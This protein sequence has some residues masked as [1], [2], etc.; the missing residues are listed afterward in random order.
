MI[1]SIRHDETNR[2]YH[3][4]SEFASCSGFKHFLECPAMYPAYLRK[5]AENEDTDFNLGTAAHMAWLERELF[6]KTY[7]RAPQLKDYPGALKTV[8]EIK[9]QLKG[10]GLPVSGKKEELQS[11]LKEVDPKAVFWDDIVAQAT[12]G[13]KL[14]TDTHWRN[15]EGMVE[16]L[17]RDPDASAL[18]KRGQQE[19]SVRW[20]DD[21]T[22]VPMKC[23]FDTIITDLGISGDLK[24]FNSVTERNV[25]KQIMRMQYHIQSAWYLRGASEVLGR[26]V[27]QF[28]HLFVMTEDPWLVV[29]YA[30]D[31]ASIERADLDVRDGLKRFAACLESKTWP[32][33][34]P[35]VRALSLPDYAFSYEEGTA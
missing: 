24:T 31:D 19:V 10:R 20:F 17:D 14:V 30:L 27:T 25:Q 8:D 15:I 32:A 18:L 28:V 23:R 2:A 7:A 9:T 5:Q 35:G 3:Q 16:S 4:D 26:R 34:L 12:I 22:G 21:E 1:H 11:R 13:R 33:P 29:P 6:A